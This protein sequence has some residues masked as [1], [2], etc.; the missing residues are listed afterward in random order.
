MVD[1]PGETGLSYNQRLYQWLSVTRRYSPLH[2][3]TLIN[4]IKLF[5]KKIKK[6][7]KNLETNQKSINDFNL[8]VQVLWLVSLVS[9]MALW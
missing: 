1:R 2:K 9:L 8:F 6:I 5:K 7:K 4:P 3:P